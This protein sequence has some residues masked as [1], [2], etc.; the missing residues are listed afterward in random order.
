LRHWIKTAATIAAISS[1]MLAV[2][3]TAQVVEGPTVEWRIATFGSPRTGT[4]HIETI[5][6][7]VEERT[8]G[9]FS[10]TLG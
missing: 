3:A 9:R 2:P 5:K 10:I 1:G 6:A 4:T 7:Y 8:E